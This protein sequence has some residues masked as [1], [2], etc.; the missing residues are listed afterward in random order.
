MLNEHSRCS[1]CGYA[2]LF[3]SFPAETSHSVLGSAKTGRSTENWKSDGSV[4]F[5]DLHNGLTPDH[6]HRKQ[7]AGSKQVYATL[8]VL[9][10]S[11][12]FP[13]Y[14]RFLSAF[15]WYC[16]LNWS[17]S[18]HG[19]SMW[20]VLPT[21]L[22][23]KRHLSIGPDEIIELVI[24]ELNDPT[25]LTLTSKRFLQVSRDPYVR[26]H[27]FLHRFGHMDAMFWALGRGKVLTD[28]VIDV[29]PFVLRGVLLREPRRLS[30]SLTI[31]VIPSPDSSLER[32]LC[33]PL[34]H[35]GG[36]TSLFPFSESLCENTMGPDDTARGVHAFHESYLW[37]V[38]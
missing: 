30:L 27:Y 20:Y 15:S 38:R 34:P 12:Y 31:C 16:W 9:L 37:A 18:P 33:I 22:P 36:H 21:I 8:I 6:H 7:R 19:A 14:P 29:R 5:R 4:A 23:F 17:S 26:A 10:E 35:T 1:P 2:L 11:D 24:Y 13:G 28:K 25:A 32:R 3:F